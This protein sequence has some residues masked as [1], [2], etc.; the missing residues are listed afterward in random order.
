MR[1]EEAVDEEFCQQKKEPYVCFKQVEIKTRIE[2]SR[3]RDRDRDK[4]WYRYRYIDV[5]MPKKI[6]ID[7]DYHH[8]LLSSV[9]IPFIERNKIAK[10][11]MCKSTPTQGTKW[12]RQSDPG[13]HD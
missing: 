1:G 6:N 7:L 8:A 3:D 5:D 13:T 4:Y 12:R 2:S 11:Q 10:Q 9:K